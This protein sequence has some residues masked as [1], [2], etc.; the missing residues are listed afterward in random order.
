MRVLRV[1]EGERA[2]PL[3]ARQGWPTRRP[4]RAPRATS[5]TLTRAS[6]PASVPVAPA[7]RWRTAAPVSGTF[8][9]LV[10]LSSVNDIRASS[11]T[12]FPILTR[13]SPSRAAPPSPLSLLPPLRHRWSHLLLLL[14]HLSPSL[15]R[16]AL[17]LRS[18][19]APRV[20]RYFQLPLSRRHFG[21]SPR[22]L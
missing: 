21:V 18:T 22:S 16:Y 20:H 13:A 7:K 4:W 8:W 5:R 6:R 9:T 2:P 10:G 15:F 19:C 17:R 14:L 1:R 11:P 12:G 3:S